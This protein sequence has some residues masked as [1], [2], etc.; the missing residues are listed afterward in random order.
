MFL[1]NAEANS[2]GWKKCIL[3]CCGNLGLHM[4]EII[5]MSIGKD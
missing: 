1:D 2:M 3:G 4:D 5:W